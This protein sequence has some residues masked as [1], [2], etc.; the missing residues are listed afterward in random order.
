MFYLLVSSKL[1][2]IWMERNIQKETTAM[3]I[4]RVWVAEFFKGEA[5]KSHSPFGFPVSGVIRLRHL[6][7]NSHTIQFHQRDNAVCMASW[8]VPQPLEC[9]FPGVMCFPCGFI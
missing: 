7:S 8:P 9:N 1:S 2:S 4:S 3:I 6:S 5:S